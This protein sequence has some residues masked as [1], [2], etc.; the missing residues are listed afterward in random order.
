MLY[1]SCVCSIVF[2]CKLCRVVDNATFGLF[3][4]QI[5]LA[6]LLLLGGGGNSTSLN[7][8]KVLILMLF[9]FE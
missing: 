4:S 3:K 8:I 6:L 9:F 5:Q 2:V 1:K 7:T